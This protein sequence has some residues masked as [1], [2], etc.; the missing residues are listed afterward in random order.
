MT[1]TKRLIL[2]Y[3][4]LFLLTACNTKTNPSSN[5]QPSTNTDIKKKTSLLSSGKKTARSSMYSYYKRKSEQTKKQMKR[6]NKR[7]GKI[8][9]ENKM[10][11]AKILLMRQRLRQRFSTMRRKIKDSRRRK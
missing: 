5:N 7:L 10:A 2:S 8:K 9:A 1:L 6:R 4:L 3:A 11:R